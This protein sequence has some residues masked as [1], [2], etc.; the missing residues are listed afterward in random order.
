MSNKPRPRY[1]TPNE[2][3]IHNT[4]KDCW[5]S[6]LGKVY[7]LTPFIEAN[8]GDILLKPIIEMAGQDISHWFDPKAKDIKKHIDQSTGCQL[9][10]TPHG[11]FSHV[12]PPF[13]AS[14]WANDF[15]KPWWKDDKYSPGILS[16]K[17][18]FLNII[19][20]LTLQKQI[21]EVCAE[22]NMFEIL[23]R[24]LKYN[25][26]AASYTWKYDCKV[27]DMN[28]TLSENGIPD[29]DADFY[30][31][32]MRDDQFLQSVILYYNDDLTEA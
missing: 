16:A 9:Y 20:G 19:N 32:R 6:F 1:F 4:A 14:D 12:P 29:D 27:L 2:V 22:E 18:R 21:V 25:A 31:L 17:T 26:H 10:H 3:S 5:V 15:G 28:K 23:Q 8:A 7:D 13:P 30:T 24:Y 11:R